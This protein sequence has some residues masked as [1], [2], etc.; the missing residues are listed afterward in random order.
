MVMVVMVVPVAVAKGQAAGRQV[1]V[2]QARQ[3]RQ[4]RQVRQAMAKSTP[5]QMT[6][7]L[8]VTSTTTTTNRQVPVTKLVHPKLRVWLQA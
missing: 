3:A 5:S 2:R 1:T 7:K 6:T 8:A 4:V